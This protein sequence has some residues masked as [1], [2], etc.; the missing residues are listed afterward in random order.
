MTQ[1]RQV[2]GVDFSGGKHAGRAIWLATADVGERLKLRKLQRLETIAGTPDRAPAL[3]CL[4]D[5]IAA[6]THTLWGIDFPFG[7][8]IEMYPDGWPTQLDAVAQWT[9]GAKDFGRMLYQRSL[10]EQ[11]RGHV[12]RTTDLLTKTPF[13]CYHYRI[14]YQTFHGMRD[15]LRPLRT[16]PATA[17]LPFTNP[18]NPKR[19][20]VETCPSST[21]K[22]LSL[23]HQNYKQPGGKPV[24]DKRH[25]TRRTIFTGLKNLIDIPPHHRRKAMQDPGG[26]ALDAIIAAV[27]TWHAWQ[28]ADHQQ[29]AKHERASREGWIYA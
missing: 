5:T 19:I 13:D 20:V 3:A 2:V 16:K 12:R 9:E 18:R 4:V 8:P 11:G 29:I 6:S 24:D 28:T 14:I 27:G 23:P 7:L 10:D 15:V 17:I 25:T 1:I 22:R 21:L 26:D